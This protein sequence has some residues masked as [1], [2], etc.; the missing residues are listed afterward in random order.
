MAKNLKP[1]HPVC[2]TMY[3]EIEKLLQ[4][5]QTYL[6]LWKTTFRDFVACASIPVLLTG[7]IPQQHIN[8]AFTKACEEVHQAILNDS[9]STNIELLQ[10]AYA[11]WSPMTA[12]VFNNCALSAGPSQPTAKISATPSKKQKKSS[13]TSKVNSIPNRS[14][15]VH[16]SKPKPTPEPVKAVSVSDTATVSQVTVADEN[17]YDDLTEYRRTTE[18]LYHA[19]RYITCSEPRCAMCDKMFRRVLLSPCVGH[20]PCVKSGWFPHVGVRLWAKIYKTHHDAGT[21]NIDV[22]APVSKGRKAAIDAIRELDSRK[23]PS[24][25]SEEVELMDDEVPDRVSNWVDS[26]L[27]LE[28]NLPRFR[29]SGSEPPPATLPLRYAPYHK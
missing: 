11:L 16:K 29:R 9:N 22:S 7:N 12:T 4:N 3:S 27:H 8:T 5:H 25:I 2:I 6:E 18:V 13:P 17:I 21:L 1:H 20:E 15:I 24:T 23:A 10:L 28:Q 19:D 26:S 14:V